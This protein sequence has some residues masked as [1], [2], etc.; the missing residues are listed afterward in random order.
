[1]SMLQ[2]AGS[3]STSPNIL[4]VDTTPDPSMDPSVATLSPDT[5]ARASWGET[6]W[7]SV[8]VGAGST[9]GW[10]EQEWVVASPKKVRRPTR[11]LKKTLGHLRSAGR[12]Q[13]W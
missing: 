10:G 11:G 12:I 6:D 13:H 4:G 9:N 5:L 3:S 8:S 7:K 1:M 2:Q